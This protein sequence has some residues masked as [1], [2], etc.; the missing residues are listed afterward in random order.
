MRTF[1][2]LHEP[3]DLGTWF[4]RFRGGGWLGGVGHRY[5]FECNS[6]SNE[7]ASMS[8]NPVTFQLLGVLTIGVIGADGGSVNMH[9]P[10]DRL[11][12]FPFA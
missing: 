11:I 3:Q 4:V 8:F 7:S 9:T 6:L 5:I 10:G 12:S 2:S 1:C